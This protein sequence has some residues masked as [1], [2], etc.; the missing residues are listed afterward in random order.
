MRGL[1]VGYG[2]MGRAIEEVLLARGHEVA[3]KVTSVGP[4]VWPAAT[5]AFE[6]TN[7][8][9]APSVLSRLAEQGISTVSGSTGWDG[10]E[11]VA[12]AF[13]QHG[14]AFLHSANFSLGMNVMYR[15]ADLLGAAAA[16]LP[17]Y[18]GGLVGA[19]THARRTRRRAPHAGSRAPSRRAPAGRYRSS[20]S[21][22][23][24]SRESTA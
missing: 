8:A 1:L 20:R 3:G 6:F 13:G 5:I 4:A 23:E 24:A 19:T 16:A 18:D 21:G 22:R 14:A 15:V 10:V 17:G 7:A 2:R 9:A 12:G 11:R